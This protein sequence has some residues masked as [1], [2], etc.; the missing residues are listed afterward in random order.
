MTGSSLHPR[1]RAAYPAR[2]PDDGKW[3]RRTRARGGPG[4]LHCDGEEASRGPGCLRPSR[5][6]PW[7]GARIRSR[8]REPPPLSA[9]PRS[10]G[11]RPVPGGARALP[12]GHPETPRRRHRA[13]RVRA[14]SAGLERLR[15]GDPTGPGG[16][17]SGPE[18]AGGAPAARRPGVL[19]CGAGPGAARCG[20][21][22]TEGGQRSG[23]RRPGNRGDARPG[24]ARAGKSATGGARPRRRSAVAAAAHAH[25]AVRG[26]KGE[27][28][29]N[30][31]S[32]ADLPRPVRSQPGRPRDCR[33]AHRAVR[34][35]GTSR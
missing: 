35:S 5:S 17:P 8:R 6:R 31:R 32:R 15:R 24:A 28:R 16:R 34:G 1:N 7:R 25:E 33:R 13:S 19:R 9:R 2:R 4:M 23:A 21:R 26:S 20:D 22:P 10:D 30:P 12:Q 27:E 29:A 3:G 14:A 18:P 11:R